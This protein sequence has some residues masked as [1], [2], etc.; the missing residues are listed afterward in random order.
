MY[1]LFLQDFICIHTFMDMFLYVDGLNIYRP[2]SSQKRFDI[3]VPVKVCIARDI[4]EASVPLAVGLF[5]RVNV[6]TRS[7]LT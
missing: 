3:K 7:T 5:Q 6:C 2:V 4:Y 1:A